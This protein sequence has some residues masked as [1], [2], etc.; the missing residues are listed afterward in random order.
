MYRAL[1]LLLLVTAAVAACGPSEEAP[2]RPAS[3]AVGLPGDSIVDLTGG[4]ATFPYPVYSRWISRFTGETGLLINYRSVGTGDGLGQLRDGT[5]DF[6]ASDVP[7]DT[8]LSGD[9]LVQL[10]LVVGAVVVAYNLPEVTVP[11]QLDGAVLADI[12]LGQLLRWDD[13]RIRALNPGVALPNVSIKHITRLDPSGTT[14]VFS[15]YLAGASSAFASRLGS[16]LEVLFP[17]GMT[18]SGNE[19]VAS[20]IKVTYGS[21]GYVEQSYA[22]LNRLPHARLRNGSGAFVA[23]T[24]SSLTAAA[25]SAPGPLRADGFPGSLLGATAPE[26]YPV[27]AFSW[28]IVRPDAISL[29][30]RRTLVQFVRWT[31][32]SGAADAEALGYAPLPPAVR[33]RVETAVDALTAAGRPQ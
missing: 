29:E 3:D 11:L 5:V 6:G 7:L 13:P 30:A 22:T 33:R 9:A 14:K 32:A 18:R 17:T 2:I 31:Q 20:E 28:L 23:A 15:A 21:I 4:G 26:A 8:A 25:A 10:P 19:G 24:P 16:D 1:G 12:F 27:A